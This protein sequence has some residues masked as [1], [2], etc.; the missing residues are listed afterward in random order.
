MKV[1][2]K[3]RV[4]AEKRRLFLAI[5]IEPSKGNNNAG[6]LW[7]HIQAILCFCILTV[8]FQHVCIIGNKTPSLL[9]VH[10][11]T[12]SSSYDHQ[13]AHFSSDGS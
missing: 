2:V 6:F 12:I 11:S 9:T 13:N 3:E 4:K 10:M 1:I 7:T 8:S 5:T